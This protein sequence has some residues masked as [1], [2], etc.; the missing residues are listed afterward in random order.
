MQSRVV[1]ASCCVSGAARVRAARRDPG[2]RAPSRLPTR[3][4]TQRA[5]PR[6][7][8]CA[9]DAARMSSRTSHVSQTIACSIFSKPS[10]LHV[11]RHAICGTTLCEPRKLCPGA[12]DES[13]SEPHTTASNPA[14]P[15]RSYAFFS[16]ERPARPNKAI[17]PG[18]TMPIRTSVSACTVASGKRG[19]RRGR[20]RSTRA[21][22]RS[23]TA[24]RV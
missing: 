13:K 8:R 3:L 5:P 16:S 17:D 1:L 11:R 24:T 9:C 7:D 14:Y 2:A 22:N 23:A 19:Q 12:S 20:G 21:A 15:S 18:R 4:A 10:W 6:F